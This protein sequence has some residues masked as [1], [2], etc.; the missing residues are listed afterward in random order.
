MILEGACSFVDS[1]E[2][3]FTFR[4][5][6]FELEAHPSCGYDY[7]DVRDGNTLQSPLLGRFC[8]RVV[9]DMLRSSGNSMLINFVTDPTVAHGGF[10]AGYWTAYG[11]NKCLI[12]IIF[13]VY[14]LFIRIGFNLFN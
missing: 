10:R 14:L 5:S 2:C 8:G 13:I 7:V 9:P 4:F 6:A 1:L 12:P 3:V 11:E